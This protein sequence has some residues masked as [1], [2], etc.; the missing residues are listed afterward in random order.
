M[1]F[2]K[3]NISAVTNQCFDRQCK[4]C[5]LSE[6]TTTK[7][8]KTGKV[9]PIIHHNLPVMENK[10]KQRCCVKR[11]SQCVFARFPYVCLWR[12]GCVTV[13]HRFAKSSRLAEQMKHVANAGLEMLQYGMTGWDTPQVMSP[14]SWQNYMQG[15]VLYRN[16]ISY[17]ILKA[18]KIYFHS[19]FHYLK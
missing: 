3:N 8:A 16:F 2:P 15:G 10:A 7:K 1:Q 6:K 17:S 12:S 18:L 5:T 4:Q 9:E 19:I 13:G 11:D 14:S